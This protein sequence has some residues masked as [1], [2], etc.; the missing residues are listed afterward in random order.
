MDITKSRFGLR[1]YSHELEAH[2]VVF[3]P[4]PVKLPS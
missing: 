3:I 1:I 2:Q 4:K